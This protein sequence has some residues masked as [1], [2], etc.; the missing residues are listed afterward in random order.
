MDIRL[1]TSCKINVFVLNKLGESNLTCLDVLF[2][3]HGAVGFS[4]V[5]LELNA[6]LVAEDTGLN[7]K[8]IVRKS[9]LSLNLEVRVGNLE[10]NV[11]DFLL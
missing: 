1:V 10:P 11:I 8:P 4:L 2:N 3:K 6:L 7:I 9:L 5:G